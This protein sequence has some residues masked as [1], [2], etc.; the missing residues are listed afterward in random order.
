[1]AYFRDKLNAERD[2]RRRAEKE[3]SEERAG[4]KRAEKELNEELSEARA[5]LGALERELEAGGMVVAKQIHEFVIQWADGDI[6]RLRD[7]IDMLKTSASRQVAWAKR[8]C[9]R[10][11]VWPR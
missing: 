11:G 8:V 4:R 9:S 3:L 7:E 5:R 1:M 2:G 6:K 10:A